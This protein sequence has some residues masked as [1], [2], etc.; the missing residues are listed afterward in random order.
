MKNF[1]AAVEEAV[2][3]A[4][5]SYKAY[6]KSLEHGC[7]LLVEGMS[8]GGAIPNI[9][10]LDKLDYTAAR[11]DL[12]HSCAE[13]LPRML[14]ELFTEIGQ[15]LSSAHKAAKET[16]EVI[17][18][19]RVVSDRITDLV[20]DALQLS[21]KAMNAS[22]HHHR[23]QGVIYSLDPSFYGHLHDD[24]DIS[25]VELE[26]RIGRVWTAFL[27]EDYEDVAGREALAESLDQGAETHL[28]QTREDRAKWVNEARGAGGSGADVFTKSNVGFFAT[29]PLLHSIA[30]ELQELIEK[31]SNE[32]KSAESSV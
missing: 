3:T 7:A 17:T 27:K 18:K 13:R 4:H 16:L 21:E 10:A 23:L 24:D 15:E 32:D 29:D 19:S 30:S 6:K 9:E 26:E 12:T 5:D 28:I 25:K 31:Q 22:V 14:L 20:R 1:S 11:E 2:K 8:P